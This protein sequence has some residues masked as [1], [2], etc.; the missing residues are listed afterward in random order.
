MFSEAEA[1]GGFVGRVEPTP[2]AFLARRAMLVGISGLAKAQ[3]ARVDTRGKPLFR[4]G[5][6]PCLTGVT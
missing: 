2:R 3:G 1:R 6:N 5:G 4:G